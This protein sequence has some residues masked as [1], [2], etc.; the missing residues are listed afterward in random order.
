MAEEKVAVGRIVL[1]RPNSDDKSSW[2][3]NTH[4][5]DLVPAI[6]VAVFSPICVNLRVFG[7]AQICTPWVTSSVRGDEPGQWN[8]PVR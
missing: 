4:A 7:D 2:G 5:G 3:G 1:Y 8:F 6:I